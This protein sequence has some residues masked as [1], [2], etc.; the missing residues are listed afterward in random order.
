MKI[1]VVGSGGREHAVVWRLAKRPG[2]DLYALPGN[3]GMARLAQCVP[4]PNLSPAS[5]LSVARALQV[6]LTVIGPEAPLV[7]G[8]VDLFRAAGMLIVGPTA[9]AALLEGSKIYAK[10][11]FSAHQIPTAAFETANDPE[12]AFRLLDRFSFPVVIKADGLA[13]GKGVIISRNRKEAEAAI[14]SLGP[15]IVIEE[16]LEG[17]EI[18][19]IVLSDGQTILPL[20]PAR[21]HKRALDGDQGPNTGGMGAFCDSSLLT[22]G[23]STE[24]MDRIIRPTVEATAFT[25]FLYA[26]L[27]MTA[28][29]P[30]LLEFNVRLGD[31]EAQA[32]LH[33]L[34]NDLAE[35][36]FAAANG[37]LAP[38][39]LT[40]KPGASVS[41]VLAA[42]GYPG[43]VR[44]GDIISGIEDAEITGATVFQ[45]GTRVG[46]S[47]CVTNG[48]RVLSVTASGANLRAA[49]NR[50]YSAIQ[51]I[52]FSGMHYRRDIGCPA[53]EPVS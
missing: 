37:S 8:V 41:V 5:I 10:Q 7:A 9:E 3:P 12:E 43:E 45:A 28:S 50:A 20:L 14:L 35:V 13:S 4:S 16:F 30:K 49:A 42:A 27:M 32:L 19:F 44:S 21:D 18:S 1:L 36:L 52:H 48:G 25:G 2:V 47:G 46:W 29:G 53:Q 24:I 22:S 33:H 23:Q 11:F 15:T 17:K 51:H 34:E 6:D 26:G 31:P 39:T 38:T 40:W